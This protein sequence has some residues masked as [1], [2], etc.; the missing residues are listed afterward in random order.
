MMPRLLT[1][2]AILGLACVGSSLRAS[3][4]YEEDFTGQDGKGWTGSGSG[5]T[6]DFSGVDW[7][8][9]GDTTGLTASDDIF[10]VE[11]GV[12]EMEDLDGPLAWES[13]S[14]IDI[15]SAPGFTVAIDLGADG[16]FE[17][18]GDIFNVTYAIDGGSATNLF[19]GV[20]DESAPGDPMTINGTPLTSTLATFSS[21]VSATG[22]SLQLF[23]EAANNAQTENYFFD[24]VSVS[25][26]PEPT[27]S[28][29]LLL[30]VA[31]TVL[32]SRR[33]RAQPT[34]A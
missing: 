17:D 6:S 2:A 22:S 21:S 34:V 10:R 3:I 15:S 32:F 28:F 8:I 5:A 20:V 30:L 19:T 25:V 7:N 31:G 29:P 14:T 16:D 1:L 33:R 27:L 12:M 9:T 26:I 23:V 13:P 4:V 18:G 24:N 11:S